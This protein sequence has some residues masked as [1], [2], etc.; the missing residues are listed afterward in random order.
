LLPFGPEPSVFSFAIEK[1]KNWNIQD[2][3]FAVVVYGCETRSLTVREEHRLKAF[4]N[5]VL[6]RIFGTKRIEV[7]VEWRELHE[8]ERRDLYSSPSIIRLT[9]SKKMRWAGHVARIG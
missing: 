5:N 3:N 2:Y 6:R 4:E 1:R 7:T 8:E 9:K